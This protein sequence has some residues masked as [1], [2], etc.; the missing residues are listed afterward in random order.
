MC[1][2]EVEGYISSFGAPT[3]IQPPSRCAPGSRSQQGT[4]YRPPSPPPQQRHPGELCGTG[5]EFHLIIIS[6]APAGSLAC[7]RTSPALRGDPSTLN[8]LPAKLTHLHFSFWETV[9]TPQMPFS[10]IQVFM[11]S[12]RASPQPN[13][14]ECGDKD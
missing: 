8:S 12:S 13:P 4:K 11:T 3:L 5:N 7:S 14:P 2:F 6:R 1:P 9:T 10:Y